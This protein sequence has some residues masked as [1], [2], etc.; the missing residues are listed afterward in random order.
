MSY[1]K[2]LEVAIETRRKDIK[3]LS[4]S[5]GVSV[6]AI[7]SV[8]RGQTRALTAENN[9]LAARYLTISPDWLA[10]GIGE[11]ESKSD[12]TD[13]FMLLDKDNQEK[14]RVFVDTLLITQPKR[15]STKV[16]SN[17]LP[18]IPPKAA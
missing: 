10:T 17:T 9:S 2:R 16:E 1:G 13:K 8:I 7:Y 14:V 12:L 15:A 4:D 11:M 18:D 6:Q 5:L 3:S